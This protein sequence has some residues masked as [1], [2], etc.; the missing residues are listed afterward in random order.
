M[1]MD[2]AEIY[3]GKQLERYTGNYL[4]QPNKD[5]P[6]DCEGLE[7]LQQQAEIAAILG[8][9]GGD[10]IILSGCGRIN[11]LGREP[12]WVF[13]RTKDYPAGEILEWTGGLTNHGMYL[14]KEDIKVSAPDA[15]YPRAYTRRRLCPGVGEENFSWNDFTELKS[16]KELMAENAELREKVRQGSPLGVVEIW[17]GNEPPEGY[18]LCDGRELK[19]D[20]YP[21]LCAVL[22]ST[23]DR[24]PSAGGWSYVTREG[25]FRVPDLRGRFVVGLGGGEGD[26]STVGKA[27]GREKVTLT[28]QTLPEHSHGFM[29]PAQGS[30][31]WRS[32]GADA[33]PNMTTNYGLNAAGRSTQSAGGGEAHEN[34]PPYYVMAYIMRTK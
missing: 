20:E 27:G 26:Y 12:G 18:V 22:G 1:T 23:F 31:T 2:T 9:I 33:S 17:A 10:R 29:I 8:N 15:E 3:T 7:Y 13:V 30:G 4:N 5:F 21:E 19:Q 24:A 34:R 28:E 6:L 14:A 11:A 32:G 16:V 25:Y